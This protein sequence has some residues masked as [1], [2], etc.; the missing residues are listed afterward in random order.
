MKDCRNLRQ[1]IKNRQNVILNEPVPSLTSSFPSKAICDQLLEAYLRTFESIYR[2]VHVPT[3]RDEH[4][5]FWQNRQASS[6]VICMKLAL[7]FAIGTTFY[8]NLIEYGRLH[9]L[10]RMWIHAAQSWLT[11]AS[12]KSALNLDGVQVACLLQL[13]RQVTAFGTTSWS[14]TDLPLRLAMSIGLHRDPSSFPSLSP[15]QAQMRRRLWYT[16]VE[17]TVQSGLG[18]SV[19]FTVST[20]HYDTTPPA[21]VNDQAVSPETQVSPTELPPDQISDNSLQLLLLQN[22][23]LRLR[24]AA[25]MSSLNQQYSHDCA[26]ETGNALKSASREIMTFISTAQSLPRT[27]S[28]SLSQFHAQFLDV[29]MRRYILLLHRPFVIQSRTDPRFYYSRKVCLE[30]TMVIASY[31][32]NLNLPAGKLDD[33]SRLL[34]VVRGPLNGPLSLDVVTMLGLELVTQLEEAGIGP[35]T[36]IDPAERIARANRTP[37]LEVLEHIK[38]QLLQIIA[39]GSPSLKRYGYISAMLAQVY[40]MENGQSSSQAVITSVKESMAT[41][42]PL[43]EATMAASAPRD[44]V[45]TL[46]N[47][48]LV[49]GSEPATSGNFEFDENFDLDDLF[50]VPDMNFANAI[51]W[52]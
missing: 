42:L 9:R 16:T 44:S 36:A 27:G 14:S 7:V 23:P 47:P 28:L 46:T 6:T 8:P 43:L 31:A 4:E 35:Y 30:T 1:T 52:S 41:V 18:S 24:I 11:G 29:Y 39:L 5:K 22:L 25:T 13:A 32:Y 37:I 17:L 12:E 34:L 48:E 20:D 3:F 26:I 49:S 19:P 2:I 45:A 51:D 15:F 33:L 38:S 40:A 10:A 50:Y 21:N